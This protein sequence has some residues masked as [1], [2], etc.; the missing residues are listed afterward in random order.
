MKPTILYIQTGEQGCGFDTFVQGLKLTIA[1]MGNTVDIFDPIKDSGM[2]IDKFCSHLKNQHSEL[3]IEHLLQKID[4]AY[5][6][7]NFIFDKGLIS[8]TD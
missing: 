1:Q 5:Q 4:R 6:K 2:T 3:L 8:N 7:S